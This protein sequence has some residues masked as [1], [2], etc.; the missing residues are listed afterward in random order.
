MTI[1]IV[2]GVLLWCSVINIGVLLLWG[3]LFVFA[4]DLVYRLHTKLFKLSPEAFDTI[5]YCGLGLYK[6]ITFSF[7]VIPYI[8]LLIVG[9]E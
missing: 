4:H 2:R 5:H 7:F 3:L 9:A 1:E 8:A 6:V